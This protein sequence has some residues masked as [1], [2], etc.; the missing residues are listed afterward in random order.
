MAL[1]KK[2]KKSNI[3]SSKDLTTIW[4]IRVAQQTSTK[5]EKLAYYR[6]MA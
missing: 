6:A 2:K 5:K 1:H 3:Y 4:R